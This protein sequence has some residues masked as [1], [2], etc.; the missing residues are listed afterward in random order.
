MSNQHEFQAEALRGI[1]Q[2]NPLAHVFFSHENIEKLQQNIRYIV[3]IKS[4]KKH[5]IDRQSD[6]QLKIIMRSIY[7]QHSKN[8][9][10]N[11]TAQV[12]ELNI[13][14]LHFC[15]PKILSEIEGYLSY[16]KHIE[17]GYAPMPRSQNVNSKGTK[18]LEMR[19]F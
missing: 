10:L 8:Q 4:C 16:R 6:E 9:P 7:L 15:V 11:I 14:V 19:S 18:V 12:D 13:K 17:E 1:L 2:H 5:I 3:W